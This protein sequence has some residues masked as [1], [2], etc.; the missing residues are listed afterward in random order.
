MNAVLLLQ[1]FIGEMLCGRRRRRGWKMKSVTSRQ[2]ENKTNSRLFLFQ[3][4]LGSGPL[5]PLFRPDE[6]DLD[7]DNPLV[8]LATKRGRLLG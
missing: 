7:R 4:W 6:D 1:L 5:A 8:V 3:T 2:P